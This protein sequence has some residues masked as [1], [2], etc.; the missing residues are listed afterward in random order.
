MTPVA[1]RRL[2][3]PALASWSW[4]EATISSPSRH[5]ERNAL[6]ST[7][8]FC[9][10]EGPKWI[11]SSAYPQPGSQP[12]VGV[13][14][15]PGGLLRKRERVVGLDLGVAVEVGEPVDHLAADVRSAGVLE[16]RPP[17]EASV[18]ESGELA[19]GVSDIE[20]SQGCLL[21]VVE[22]PEFARSRRCSTEPVAI[23]RNRLVEADAAPLFVRGFRCVPARRP[24]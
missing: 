11:S 22:I 10:V 12:A 14:D 17:L 20:G 6:A 18:R 7:Y 21:W 8:V 1:S 13:L 3:T 15:R 23:R 4:V 9:E 2:H 19:A 24:V 5:M 16:V